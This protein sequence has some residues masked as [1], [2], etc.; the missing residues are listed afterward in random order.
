MSI[1]DMTIW[2]VAAGDGAHHYAYNC[3]ASGVI[4]MGPGGHGR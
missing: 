3:L 1:E 4:L 2:Q